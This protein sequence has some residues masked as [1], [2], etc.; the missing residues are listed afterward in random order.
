MTQ[1]TTYSSTY[2]KKKLMKKIKKILPDRSAKE[3]CLFQA[4]ALKMSRQIRLTMIN[5][6]STTLACILFIQMNK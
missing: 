5:E 4:V 1:P 3:N 6:V 2:Y